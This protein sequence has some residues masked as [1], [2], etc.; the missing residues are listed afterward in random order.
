MFGLSP[1]QVHGDEDGDADELRLLSDEDNVLN[2]R[3]HGASLSFLNTKV[4]SP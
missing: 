1:L 3:A 4:D 2:L